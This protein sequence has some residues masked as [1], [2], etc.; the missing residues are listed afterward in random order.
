MKRKTGFWEEICTPENIAKAYHKC[1][2]GKGFYREIKE[3]GTNHIYY[4]DEVL[5]L[6]KNEEYTPSP[7]RIKIIH[8]PKERTIYATSVFPDRMVHHAIMN[9]LEPFWAKL[10]QDNS[11]ACIKGRGTQAAHAKIVE[12]IRKY[13]WYVQLDARK[14][15]PSLNHEKMKEIIRKKIK[16]PPL[17]RTLDKIIDS[18]DSPTNIPIGNFTS[19]WLGNLYLNELDLWIVHKWHLHFVRFCDDTYVFSN[20]REY[21]KKFSKEIPLFMKEEL[22]L[23]LSKNRLACVRSCVQALGYRSFVDF[24]GNSVTTL[25]RR[26]ARNIQKLCSSLIDRGALES[27][28]QFTDYEIFK[29]DHSLASYKGILDFCKAT[30]FRQKYHFDEL[31]KTFH[32]YGADM[33]MQLDKVVKPYDSRKHTRIQDILGVPVL[34][35]GA[36]IGKNTFYDGKTT[37]NPDVAIF[38]FVK[39]EDVQGDINC[40]EDVRKSHIENCVSSAYPLCHYARELIEKEIDFSKVC[41][42]VKFVKRGL[43]GFTFE[44]INL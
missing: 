32:V 41:I 19:Q 6:L 36:S 13:K 17:L 22:K 10:M 31:Y 9:V 43:K 16:D 18:I 4:E 14:F 38:D 1:T 27:T 30:R 23:N 24:K 28:V 21:L 26:T 3:I 11:F 2:L 8:E 37:K 44:P 34:I 29:I 15:Y 5:R 25:K 33:L 39:V 40:Q 12:Y 7:Y 42:P 20:D 35:V